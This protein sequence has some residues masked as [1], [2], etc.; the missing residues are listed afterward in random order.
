MSAARSTFV[1]WLIPL[2]L[3]AIAGAAFVVF[4]LTTKSNLYILTTPAGVSVA[5]NGG[6]VGVTADSGLVLAVE[7]GVLELVLSR[8]GFEDAVSSHNVRRGE[9]I[10]IEHLMKREGMEFVRGG[11]FRMGNDDGAYSEKPEHDVTLAPYYIDTSEV[12]AQAY[13]EYDS[14]YSP[15]FSAAGLPATGIA[16]EE[17]DAYCKSVGKRLPTEAEWERACAG[18]EGLPYAY[19][20]AY[21]AMLARTGSR[22][23]DEPVPVGQYPA[24]N[25]GAVDMTGNVWEWCSDWHDRDTYRSSETLNPTGPL[26]GDRHVLRGGAWYS[27]ASFSRCTH[28][29]GNFRS[30]R[31][32]SFGFR[33]ARDL[34]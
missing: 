23:Q 7:P 11:R 29:P 4:W 31:D 25:A 1:L 21:D 27:N 30:Q 34:D 24:G 22:V 18:P 26:R 20:N 8:D 9:L 6:I 10:E 12:T 2:I 5:V 3:V 28:R 13:K 33:C 32:P 14:S 17:A 16:W 15:V 19:G